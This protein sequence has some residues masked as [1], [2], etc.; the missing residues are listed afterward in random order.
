MNKYPHN[1]AETVTHKDV[2][3]AKAY[4]KLHAR[5]EKFKKALK[6]IVKLGKDAE[7]ICG[8]TYIEAEIIASKALK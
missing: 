5:N 8:N 1:M 7:M 6:A 3:E 2:D 4:L